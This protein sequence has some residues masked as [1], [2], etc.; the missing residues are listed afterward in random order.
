MRHA[1]FQTVKSDNEI[2]LKDAYK[3]LD[4][5]HRYV[6]INKFK[7]DGDNNL[8]V[9]DNSSPFEI[10]QDNFVKHFIYN[11]DIMDIKLVISNGK[12][13]AKNGHS[14]ISDEKQILKFIAK[15]AK[16]IDC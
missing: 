11:R 7:G 3:R 14:T 16:R 6:K 15:Q 13:V 10:T 4:A 5:I 2:E 12:I 8:I 9:F 1:Y